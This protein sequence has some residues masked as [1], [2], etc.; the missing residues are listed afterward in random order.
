M[1]NRAITSAENGK[2]G[3]RPKG[4]KTRPQFREYMTPEQM[5]DIVNMM[6]REA[7][8]GKIDAA[9][10]LGDQF[11][12]KALQTQVQED[13]DGNKVAP[14]LV[15]FITDEGDRNPDRV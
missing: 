6:Y 2:K 15:K 13:E 4:S 8:D 7:L 10:W 12:G 14:V 9:K 5:E 11:F 1:D 3:G